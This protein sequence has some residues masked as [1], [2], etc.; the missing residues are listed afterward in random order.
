[1][2]LS[3]R[4]IA[5]AG[6]FGALTLFLGMTNWGFFPIPIPLVGAVTIMQIPVIM[7]GIYAGPVVAS[8]V[9]LLFGLFTLRFMGDFRVV[10]P[11]RLLIGVVAWAAFA[12][13]Q[14]ILRRWG[15]RRRAA[16]GGALA[17]FL[18]SAC[19][20]IGTLSLATL[21]GYMTPSVAWSTGVTLGLPEAIVSAAITALLA[22]PLSRFFSR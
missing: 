1:M 21:C 2:K 13:T 8:A 11:A 5:L 10:I 3:T 15:P 22:V 12:A 20:T 17:G 14:S 16:I 19:N 18:G 4:Q 6:M 7:S 9:G